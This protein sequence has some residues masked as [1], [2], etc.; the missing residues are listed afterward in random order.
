MHACAGTYVQP[1]ASAQLLLKKAIQ[2]TI[3]GVSELLNTKE[4]FVLRVSKAGMPIEHHGQE[5]L[6][7]EELLTDAERCKDLQF[8]MK[9]VKTNQPV[10]VKTDDMLKG[11][12]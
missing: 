4:E 8:L 10:R 5:A 1:S 3:S 9:D 2:A 7:R 11:K 12:K 6:A